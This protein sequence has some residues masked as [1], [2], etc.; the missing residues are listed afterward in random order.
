MD[1][2]RIF[3]DI[4][5]PEVRVILFSLD[6]RERISTF[7]KSLAESLRST[8]SG[9]VFC[10]WC[11]HLLAPDLRA[12][13][14]WKNHRLIS[15]PCLFVSELK[16]YCEQLLKEESPRFIPCFVIAHS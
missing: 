13:N 6:K 2:S 16:N 4:Y 1:I 11:C 8:A 10:L 3:V 7:G 14:N 12:P 5:R 15:W 9:T